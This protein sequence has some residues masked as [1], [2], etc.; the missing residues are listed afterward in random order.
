MNDLVQLASQFGLVESELNNLEKILEANVTFKT[1]SRMEAKRQL[2]NLRTK[3]D[4]MIARQAYASRVMRCDVRNP[5]ML[6]IEIVSEV[7]DISVIRIMGKS[8]K[9][10]VKNAR[11]LAMRLC[12]EHHLGSTKE[13]GRAFGKHYTT[14]V[15]AN[16]TAQDMLDT[17]SKESEFYKQYRRCQIRIE[18]RLYIPL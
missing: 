13:I 1:I 17:Y 15:R 4:G 5:I 10:E 2:V 14:V 12:V 9:S 7:C 3:V 18:R 8:H 6:V 11:K 16:Q